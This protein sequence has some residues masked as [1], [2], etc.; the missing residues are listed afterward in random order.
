MLGL[1]KMLLHNQIARNVYTDRTTYPRVYLCCY[2]HM[3]IYMFLHTN[4]IVSHIGR[5]LIRSVTQVII[6]IIRSG[7]RKFS[8]SINSDKYLYPPSVCV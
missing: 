6:I 4:L 5:Q 1:R 2:I 3:Y 7:I 8:F